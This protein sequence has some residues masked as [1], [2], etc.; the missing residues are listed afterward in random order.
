MFGRLVLLLLVAAPPRDLPQNGRVTPQLEATLAGLPTRPGVYLMRDA[1]GTVL[2][3]GKAQ[4]LRSR[5]RSYWQRQAIG[6][7]SGAAGPGDVH[8]IR[9]VI[10]KVADLEYTLTDSVSEAL[11]LEANLIKRYQPRFNVRLKDDKSYPYIRITLGDDFPRIERT[12]KLVQRRQPL[13]RPVRLGQQR[14]R[15]DEPDPAPLPVPYLHDRHPGGGAGPAETLPAL[16]HQTLPGPLHRGRLEGG[17]PRR[18]RPGRALPRGAAGDAGPGAAPRDGGGLR[19]DRL[20]ARGGDAGQG[21]GDRADDGGPEDGRLRP[22]RA[23]RAGPGPVGQPGGGPGLRRTGREAGRPRRL[24]AGGAGRGH[25]RRDARRVRAPVLRPLD[26][27]PAGDPGP[28]P[29]GRGRRPGGVPRRPPR[30]PSAAARPR[31]RREAAPG[32]PGG[33]QRSRPPGAGAGALARRRR[34]DAGRP[35]G[36][37]RGPG[38]GRPA[39]ADRVLRHLDD[40]GPRDGRQHGR[41]RGRPAADRRLPPLPDQGRRGPGRLREPRRDAPAAPV[42]GQGGRGGERRGAALGPPG[43]DRRGRRQGSAGRRRGGAARARARR[44]P[45]RRA[46]QGARGALPARAP[47]P[48]RSFPRPRRRSTWS[49][50]SATRPIASRSPTTETCA[51]GRR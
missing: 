23:R 11:L 10:D 42:P 33:P 37:G 25:R 2:Y 9:E 15:G 24:R 1:R 49:S 45:D 17:L 5:V 27:D 21:A 31:A 19:S 48:G 22:Y 41:L 16:P 43:P 35:R 28:A 29:P 44:D 34:Q 3:V 20:R 38:A 13:L 36:A 30:A 46:G 51:G 8:R 39:P 12:R 47:G 7:G 18:R 6:G 14:R 40:P 4:N 26:V 32:R 50:G